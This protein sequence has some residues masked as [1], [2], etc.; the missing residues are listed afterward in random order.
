MINLPDQYVN[1][2]SKS[3]IS[4]NDESMSYNINDAKCTELIT[5]NSAIRNKAIFI[6]LCSVSNLTAPIIQNSAKNIGIKTID[7]KYSVIVLVSLYYCNTVVPDCACA[8]NSR[9]LD[10]SVILSINIGIF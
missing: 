7:A 2:P 1:E 6:A 10:N 4:V 3:C 9:C 8:I 5:L